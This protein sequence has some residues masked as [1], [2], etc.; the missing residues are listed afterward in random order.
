M[1]IG[2]GAR[3]GASVLLRGIQCGAGRAGR[4]RVGVRCRVQQAN[5]K[6][7]LIINRI[8]NEKE[9]MQQRQKKQQQQK[10]QYNH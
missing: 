1:G 4:G 5:V 8:N 3:R 6:E 2:E 7:S 10:E 9:Q